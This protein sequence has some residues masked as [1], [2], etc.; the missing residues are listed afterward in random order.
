MAP[1]IKGSV[2]PR[3]LADD[4]LVFDVKIRKDRRVLGYAPD[5]DEDRAEK[6]VARYLVP[7]AQRGE[8]WWELIP[9]RADVGGE[10]IITVR[11]AITEWIEE[12]E[13]KH[14]NPSTL[15]AFLSPVEKHVLPFFA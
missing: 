9:A 3:R 10:D 7:A 13:G 14:D 15:S 8:A 6:Y 2:I 11:R 12:I 4:T 1:P 5:W